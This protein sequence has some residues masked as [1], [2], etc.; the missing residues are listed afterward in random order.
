MTWDVTAMELITM[1]P[2][3]SYTY[4]NTEGGREE[5]GKEVLKI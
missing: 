1:I 4:T 3:T 2:A 5:R